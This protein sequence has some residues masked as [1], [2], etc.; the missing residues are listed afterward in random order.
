VV[1]P[2]HDDV[3]QVGAV[4]VVTPSPVVAFHVNWALTVL[5]VAS[6]AQL[7]HRRYCPLV[8]YTPGRDR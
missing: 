3:I 6:V 5:D 2:F 4:T 8:Q 7:L 1:Q